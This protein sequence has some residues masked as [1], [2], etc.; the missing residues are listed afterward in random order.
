M[1]VSLSSVIV[2]AANPVYEIL[3]TQQQE[4][5]RYLNIS[6]RIILI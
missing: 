5:T 6:S 2:Y 3:S 1:A 4:N